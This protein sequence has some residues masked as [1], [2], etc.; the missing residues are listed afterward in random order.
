MARLQPGTFEIYKLPKLTPSFRMTSRKFSDV[1]VGTTV[2]VP[3]ISKLIMDPPK[4]LA[5]QNQM[6]LLYSIPEIRDLCYVAD[7]ASE[8]YLTGV[9]YDGEIAAIQASFNLDP[10]LPKPLDTLLAIRYKDASGDVKEEY[11]LADLNY[12]KP[13]DTNQEIAKLVDGKTLIGLPR[14]LLLSNI[15]KIENIK[16]QGLDYEL[17]GAIPADDDR[18]FIKLVDDQYQICFTDDEVKFNG[19]PPRMSVGLYRCSYGDWIAKE[20]EFEKVRS[21]PM[22][23][24]TSKHLPVAPVDV[25]APSDQAALSATVALLFHITPLR[26]DIIESA[27]QDGLVKHLAVAFDQLHHGKAIALRNLTQIFNACGPDKSILQYYEELIGIQGHS[28]PNSLYSF[29]VDYSGIDQ[30]F[31]PVT[32]HQNFYWLDSDSASIPLLPRALYSMIHDRDAASRHPLKN[33][34]GWNYSVPVYFLKAC[35]FD[36]PIEEAKEYWNNYLIIC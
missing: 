18:I 36:T 8:H 19:L 9:D 31:Q 15:L 14:Y 2:Y 6:T 30:D 32:N 23:Y 3:Y 24:N 1:Q 12:V 34:T 25:N 20:A 29:G 27:S 11:P 10:L 33:I 13:E 22:I 4:K 35:D 17:V 7:P 16:I 28:C 26:N 21:Q 5:Y